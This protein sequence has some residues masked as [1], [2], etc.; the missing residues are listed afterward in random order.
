MRGTGLPRQP[1]SRTGQQTRD[2]YAMTTLK[3]ANAFLRAG[4]YREA[5]H[6]FEELQR[7]LPAFA[8]YAK[9][10]ALAKHYWMKRGHPT[11]GLLMRQKRT[12]THP[13][14]SQVQAKRNRRFVIV[15]PVFNG[16]KFLDETMRSILGQAGDFE[17][18]YTIKDAGSTDGTLD[19]LA[20]WQ[21]RIA[22][23]REPLS[24]CRLTLAVESQP[25]GGLYDALATAFR[26][27]GHPQ[28][29]DDILAYLNADDIFAPNAFRIAANVFRTTPAEWICG[30]HHTID[31][32]GQTVHRP[33]SPNTYARED[34]IDGAHLGGELLPFIQQEGSFWLR[35]LYERSGG[36][37]PALKLAGDYDLW[38]KF[39]VLTD[40]V[41]LDRPLAAFRSRLGQLSENFYA[42]RDEVA[43]A[44]LP[45]ASTAG[46]RGPRDADAPTA[47]RPQ[48]PGP[49]CFLH[50]DLS[51]R[52]IVMIKAN[53]MPPNSTES[54]PSEPCAPTHAYLTKV[55]A[56]HGV[57]P[58]LYAAMLVIWHLRRATQRRFPLQ[59]GCAR[60][61]L[62]F[63]AWCATDGRREYVLLR[64]IA[65]WDREL[66][67]PV[68]LPALRADH[69]AGTH[70]LMNFL[71]GVSIHR[72]SLSGMLRLAAS[73]QRAARHFWRG[74]RHRNHGPAA[75]LWQRQALLTQY[76]NLSNFAQT[77]AMRKHRGKS[78]DFLVDVYGLGDLEQA[79]AP[80]LSKLPGELSLPPDIT[81]SPIP[82]PRWLIRMAEP[83]LQLW[84][85][86]PTDEQS[87]RL[88]SLLNTR[89]HVSS[90]TRGR[91][92]V[93]LIGFA[94]G[95][96]GIGEDIRQVAFALEATGIPVCILDFAPGKNI[97][98]A[99]DS[100]S[101]FLSDAPLYGINIFCLTGIETTRYVCER[102]LSTLEGRYNIG[103]WP[104]ELP[105]W[106]ENCRHAYACVDEVW[107][108]SEYTAHAHRFAAPRPVQPM[109]L[110]VALGPVGARTRRDFGL[111][112]DDYLYCFAFDINS[113][114]ARKNPEGLITAFQKAFP[115]G[116]REKVGLVLKISH[117]ETGCKLW[118]RI[119]RAA[120]HDPRI[121]LVEE[122]LRRPDLLSLFNACDCFVSL[123]RAEGFGR[124]LAEALLLGKQLIATGFSGNK[125]FCHEP[126]VALVRHTMVPLGKGDYMWGDGQSWAN[127]DLEHAAE[128]MRSVRDNP[129]PVDNSGFPFAP[130]EVGAH[131]ANR[132]REIWARHDPDTHRPETPRENPVL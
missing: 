104:W 94:R 6:A 92:G 129:R 61:Q 41:A 42:Y 34:I 4:K 114:A 18:H 48:R 23:G 101:R 91:F 93:N 36:L 74:A 123:H 13:A 3:E 14:N 106:P 28:Q 90:I 99:E 49:I 120:R 85:R 103:L 125:D 38:L 50:E 15:T 29:P 67:A 118:R 72:W 43:S 80:A 17:I 56:G 105:D 98:Q 25:D 113:S 77:I 39:A 100:A 79:D 59:H 82:L 12:V 124:C 35:T 47:H 111:P 132:L 2:L 117:P 71:H 8:P 19:L 22:A 97:S 88:M 31:E 102:G 57:G 116:S 53:G 131:Y 9:G 96:L 76:G 121:H 115:R 127:P 109:G 24:C 89:P 46:A 108:I 66:T 63:L 5:M 112:E 119:R 122:T 83:I 130:E 10:Y 30:Q 110:P 126:R 69:W 86:P 107:G 73:R 1:L 78:R 81:R 40:L 37:N 68:N 21:D 64:E 11:P 51:V 87:V 45:N 65:D 128:L 27:G 62:R 44:G 84:R 32:H 7:G 60:D 70:S 26:R 58:N 55:E 20:D 16:T 52:E 75:D 33:S 54:A 95:E